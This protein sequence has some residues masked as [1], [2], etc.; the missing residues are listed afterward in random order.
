MTESAS[1]SN[2]TSLKLL[3]IWSAIGAQSFGGGPATLQLIFR[4]MV[5]RRHWL[6]EEE[7][8]RYWTFSPLVPGINLIAFAILIGRR[9]AGWQG[10]LATLF[11]MLIPSAIITTILTA[12]FT[13]IEQW[14]PFQSMLKGIIPATGG[15]MFA[16]AAQMG[17]P[18]LKQSYQEG[19][20]RLALSLGFVTSAVA[21][22]TFLHWPV[23]AVLLTGVT[24]GAF[25]L[26]PPTVLAEV[27]AEQADEEEA[28]AVETTE[29]VSP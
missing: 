25:V 15:L 21:L 18:M 10:I 29:E 9:L 16:L 22:I 28:K 8:W 17:V 5:T 3:G 2:P 11:G 14:P 1:S 13:S 4:E 27:K 19:R 20:T 24:A 26:A 12:G 23:V 7:Y 6:S